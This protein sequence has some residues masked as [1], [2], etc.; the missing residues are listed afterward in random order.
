MINWEKPLRTIDDRNVVGILPPNALGLR[1]VTIRAGEGVPS[2]HQYNANGM[3]VGQEANPAYP[4]HLM[5]PKIKKWV[6]LY[7]SGTPDSGYVRRT[8]S[9]M[10]KE[11]AVAEHG[12]KLLGQCSLTEEEFDE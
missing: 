9:K 3:F 10:T 1:F 12:D 6:W 2:V 5:N 11:Q 7:A 4:Y 8:V